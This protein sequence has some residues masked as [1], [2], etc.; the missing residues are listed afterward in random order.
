MVSKK[1]NRNSGDYVGLIDLKVSFHKL[2]ERSSIDREYWPILFESFLSL[3]KIDSATKIDT[4]NF[5]YPDTVIQKI[6]E[7]GLK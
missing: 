2:L 7:S 1:A 6:I 4:T 5:Y 3:F